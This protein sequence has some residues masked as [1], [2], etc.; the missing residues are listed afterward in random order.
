MKSWLSWGGAI[1]PHADKQFDEL[2]HEF[3]KA[4][5]KI[6]HNAP[7]KELYQI[8]TDAAVGAAGMLIC[9]EAN[10]REQSR[11]KKKKK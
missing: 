8:A 3:A 7:F 4:L 2:Q 5:R 6:A 11:E 9:A 10:R 1:A